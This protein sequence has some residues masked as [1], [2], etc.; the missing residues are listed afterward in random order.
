M[1]S[2]LNTVKGIAEY[3]RSCRKR[4]MKLSEKIVEFF[5]EVSSVGRTTA[6][7]RLHNS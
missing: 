4:Q 6:I 7:V 3:G 5:G 1:I 2:M